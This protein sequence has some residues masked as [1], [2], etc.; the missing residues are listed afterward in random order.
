MLA[1][2]TVFWG[3]ITLFFFRSVTGPKLPR[4]PAGPVWKDTYGQWRCLQR[5]DLGEAESETR[6]SADPRPGRPSPWSLA[7][8]APVTSS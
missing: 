2:L 7:D 4:A 8:E 5:C 1:S 3:H 6:H